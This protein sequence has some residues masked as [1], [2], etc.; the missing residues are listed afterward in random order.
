MSAFLKD[1][2]SDRLKKVSNRSVGRS[3]LFCS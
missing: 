2:I 3:F 1:I